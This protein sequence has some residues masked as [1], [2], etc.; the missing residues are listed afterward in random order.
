MDDFTS[1]Y[2]GLYNIFENEEERLALN[3]HYDALS[4]KNHEALLLLNERISAL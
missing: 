4:H 3:N 1:G 2:K